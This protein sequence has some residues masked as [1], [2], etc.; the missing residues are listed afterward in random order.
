M[1]QDELYQETAAATDLVVGNPG[2]EENK[3]KI[4]LD[5]KHGQDNP[6]DIEM[7]NIQ[8]IS[9]SHIYK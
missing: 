6:G 1:V 5:V 7:L 3:Y 8:G 2:I 9:T 4:P